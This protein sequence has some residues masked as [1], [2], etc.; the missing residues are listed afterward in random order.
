MI[1]IVNI[2]NIAASEAISDTIFDDSRTT[3]APADV[4]NPVPADIIVSQTKIVWAGELAIYGW[5]PIGHLGSLQNGATVIPFVFHLLW[6]TRKS[7]FSRSTENHS[8]NS[9][10]ED[11]SKALE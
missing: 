9:G 8:N 3:R 4:R 11:F 10:F 2:E 1:V 5:L 6:Q 7:F